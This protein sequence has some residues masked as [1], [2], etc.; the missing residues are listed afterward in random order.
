MPDVLLVEDDL[1]IGRTLES[2][3]TANRY[4]V[5]WAL[6]GES[7]IAAADEVAYDLILLDLGLPDMDG[8]DTCRVLRE[9]QPGAVIVILTARDE[10]IDV[11]VGLDAG[12]DDYLT[13]PVR[14]SELLARIRAHLRR[15]SAGSPVGDS[16]TNSGAGSAHRIHRVGDLQVDADA[17]RA[18]I[19]DR[20]VVL[21]A[22]EFD[23]LARLASE[24]RTA[25]SREV[26]MSDVWD[27]HWHG[28]T[29]T[30]DVHVAMLRRK[31]SA[32]AG[33]IGLPAPD[34]VTLR[35][36]GYRIQP[37]HDA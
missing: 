32:T 17:R 28:S 34:I 36:R 2:V 6:D 9:R 12:A 3:L 5:H 37:A 7:A 30:L 22:K 18:C 27:E 1:T 21:R 4:H 35:G 14:L 31:L 13:K 8:V 24:P 33:E 10:E 16:A 25:I 29:K 11:V 23:L 20:E 26:L 15:G 19:G